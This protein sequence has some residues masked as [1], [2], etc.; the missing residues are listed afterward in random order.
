M[1]SNWILL[2]LALLG[3]LTSVAR[4]D[5]AG[6]SVVVTATRTPQPA[7]KTGESISIITARDLKTQ[8]IVSLTD[9]LQQIPGLIAVRNGGLGQNATVS[10][11]AAEAGQTL[12][13]VDGA[14]I[15]D[16]STVDNEAL[17]G[18]LLVNNIERVE[19]LRGPQST[20]YGSDAIGGVMDVITR[21]G[22]GIPFA[23]QANAEG[24]SFDTYHFN[25]AANGSS[26]DVEYGAAANFLHTN[27]ISAADK[28]NGNPETDGYTNAGGTENLRVHLTDTISVDLRSYYTNAQDH[29][30]DN[31][32]FVPPATFRVADSPA[33]GRNALFAG[34]GG[35]NADLFEGMFANRFAFIGSDSHRAFYDSGFDTVHKNSSDNGDAWRFEYQGIL[36]LVPEDQMTFGAEYQRIEFTGTTFSSFA[37]QQ[38]DDGSSHVGSAYAQNMLTLFDQL[39]LTAGLRH[40]DD[41]E[42][43]GRNS[44]KLAAAWSLKDRGTVLHA[45]YGDGFKAPTLFEQFS[46]FSNPLHALLPEVAH[47]WEAGVQ[48]GLF[49]GGLLVQ[50]TYFQRRNNDQIDF[51]APNC[52]TEPPPDVCKTRPFGYYDNIAR[53]RADGVELEATA[54]VADTLSLNAS[55]TDMTATDLITGLDLARRPHVTASGTV[56]W[57]PASAWSTGAAVIYVGRRFDAAG[58][59][60]P[61]STYTVTNLFGSCKVTDTFEVYARMEN[62]FD[63]QYEPVFGYGAAGRAVYGG[64]RLAY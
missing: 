14:R 27:G 4:A 16:L 2:S 22:G 7:E 50:A 56:T 11:R 45:N 52:F 5:D 53:T 60:N 10:I 8:Q 21:R 37:P 61:L 48:Q 41:R 15:N 59:S 47:G 39:T 51:F 18:D 42:F 3:T 24:G 6:E 30:D 46:Q 1:R 33:Y 43:G 54:H 49:D 20:L 32:V 44:I 29:F 23:L 63:A 34:Y 12:V 31:F 17:L 38:I 25:L 36:Q 40:D 62:V 13:L 55:F 35:L 19:I 26:G 58:E 57:T 9:V 64:I 28:R